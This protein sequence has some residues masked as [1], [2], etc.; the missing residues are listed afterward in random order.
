MD[1]DTP[2]SS[3]CLTRA[4]GLWFDD[5]GLIIQA[6]ES[7][8]TIFRISKDFLARQSPVFRDMSSFPTAKNADMM[9]G[10]PFVLL[11]DSASDVTVFS[12]RYC[13]MSE[14]FFEPFP[15]STTLQILTGVLRMSHKYEVDA[16]RKRA[17]T[18]ISNFHPTTLHDYNQLDANSSPWFTAVVKRA[19][20]GLGL[21]QLARQLSLDWIL[22]AVFYG[23]CDTQES[24]IL[25]GTELHT[26]DKARCVV[27][28]RRLE[29]LGVNR[30]LDFLWEPLEIDG[31][32]S[33]RTC[34]QARV[35]LRRSFELFRERSEVPGFL[36]FEIWSKQD[37]AKLHV[38]HLCLSSMKLRTKRR[39]R[40]SGP[41]FPH[42][43]FLFGPSSRG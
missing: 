9:E 1:E 41:T 15:T 29:K 7:E 32:T 28:I 2:E 3:S 18:H 6:A 34:S 23:I 24:G 22:P 17:I 30:V 11:P 38:C 4:E 42:L 10:C 19:S 26:D 12:R 14:I 33:C 8:T 40:P 21:L 35:T 20:G 37:W 39:G 25:N 43:I 27:G 16:L 36:P 13:T 31:C 5:C